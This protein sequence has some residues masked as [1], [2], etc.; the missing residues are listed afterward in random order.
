MMRAMLLIAGILLLTVTWLGPLPELA[1]QAFFGHMLMHVLVIAVAA[2][3]IVI[4]AAGT[5]LDPA[6]RF[7]RAF[8]LP[9][10]PV[11]AA[12]LEFVV[13][14]AWHAPALHHAAR[15]Y[16][17]ALVFEQVS[18]LLVGLLIWIAA[19][20]GGHTQRKQRAPGG[21]AGL[22]LTSMHMALL[23]VLLASAGRPLYSH[24]DLPQGGLSVL[25]DQQVGGAIM[26][27]FG[28]VTYLVGALY[29]LRSL[30]NENDDLPTVT[31]REKSH[32][33]HLG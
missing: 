8:G 21:I 11:L 27:A 33:N 25:Q 22:L 14:W 29:L 6:I 4:G 5:W 9:A 28:G 2:P 17:G 12:V 15:H 23:G 18:Y 7:P 13:V 10:L 31:L 1:R 16:P 32:G 19:F 30:L 3:L 26:L 24:G 20:G